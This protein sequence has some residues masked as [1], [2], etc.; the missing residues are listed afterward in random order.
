MCKPKGFTL[1]EL[2]VVIALTAML[3]PVLI[4]ALANARKVAANVIY[5]SNEKQ[6]L[7]VWIINT[8]LNSDGSDFNF[9][10]S[11]LEHRRWRDKKSIYYSTDALVGLGWFRSDY[12]GDK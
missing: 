9:V 5:C 6:L 11:D 12:Q 8:D 10:D 3:L 7:H 4:P 2:L 1:V